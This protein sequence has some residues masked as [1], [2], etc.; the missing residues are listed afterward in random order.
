MLN[1]F[2]CYLNSSLKIQVTLSG[3]IFTQTGPQ[4]RSSSPARLQLLLASF[5]SLFLLI[6]S[7]YVSA[8]FWLAPGLRK[9]KGCADAARVRNNF[10]PL[11][12]H[13]SPHRA[14]EHT[15]SP[16]LRPWT[17]R[18]CPLQRVAEGQ[19]HC[20]SDGR[21]A[22]LTE[23]DW[24]E[25]SPGPVTASQRVSPFSSSCARWTFQSSQLHTFS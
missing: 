22:V 16:V 17:V 12:V 24:R 1:S 19:G 13:A 2:C 11:P 25:P 10:P 3:G 20:P 7:W 21:P 23:D 6:L 18:R 14:Q 5:H 15:Q 8:G 4:S 9:G